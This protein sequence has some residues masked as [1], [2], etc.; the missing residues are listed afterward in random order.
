MRGLAVAALA[1]EAVFSLILL[2]FGLLGP[3]WVRPAVPTIAV[4]CIILV[5]LGAALFRRGSQ[6][7]S[8]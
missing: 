6:R 1:L 3:A 8:P 2:A 4:S 5:V 7:Y